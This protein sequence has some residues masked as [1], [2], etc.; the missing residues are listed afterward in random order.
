MLEGLVET[1]E[2]ATYNLAQN[3]LAIDLVVTKEQVIAG[4]YARYALKCLGLRAPFADKTTRQLTRAEIALLDEEDFLAKPQSPAVNSL[5]L[6]ETAFPELPIDR[7]DLVQPTDEEAA[8][9]AAKRIFQ[10]RRTRLELISGEVGEH[11]FGE[12]LKSALEEID[13]QEKALLE[14]FLGKR[15]CTEEKHRLTLIPQAEKKQYI[16]CRFSEQDGVLPSTDLSGEIVLLDIAPSAPY[17][18]EEAP[19]KSTAV[20]ECRV[21][22]PCNCSLRLSGR[23]LATRTL[24]LFA[25]GR[26]VLVPLSRKR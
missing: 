23:E 22:A 19:E 1:S 13:R 11:V 5:D 9:Q 10:L 14:L 12:G 18:V 15:I 8:V 16:L 25:Y 3:T 26:T 4:P 2:G 17:A 6:S 20:A 24:P 7:I 21:A